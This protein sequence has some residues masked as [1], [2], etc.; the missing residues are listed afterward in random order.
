ML[1]SLTD[2]KDL[3]K[4]LKPHATSMILTIQDMV[5]STKILLNITT[6]EVSDS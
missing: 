4:I 1:G 5:A 6:K 2:T 3:Q